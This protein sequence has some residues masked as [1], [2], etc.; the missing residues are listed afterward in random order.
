MWACGWGEATRSRHCEGGFPTSY[1]YWGRWSQSLIPII[2]SISLQNI[3]RVSF[4]PNIHGSNF[5]PQARLSPPEAPPTIQQWA[6]LKCQGSC[7]GSPSLLPPWI[8][9][10]G[11]IQGRRRSSWYSGR[12]LPLWQAG[13][14]ELW[15]V[16]GEGWDLSPPVP[17]LPLHHH[18]H[19]F[20]PLNHQHHR[21][22]FLLTLRWWW[23]PFWRWVWWLLEDGWRFLEKVLIPIPFACP[24][25][26]MCCLLLCFTL[27]QPF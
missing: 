11:Q 20:W 14:E 2:W 17:V 21:D 18:N 3:F 23:Q 5:S 15:E 26:V 8:W 9:E 7:R 6:P 27:F 24:T 16:C 25:C 4:F 10:S 19:Q 13:G 22:T 12:R 1:I